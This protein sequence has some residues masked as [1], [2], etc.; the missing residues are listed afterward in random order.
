MIWCFRRHW[1][2]LGVNNKLW[3]AT[4]IIKKS[5]RKSHLYVSSSH[6]K[7]IE[8]IEGSKKVELL[9]IC[10]LLL[11]KFI[12]Y[13]L[14]LTF[15]IPKLY[16]VTSI[17]LVKASSHFKT[18]YSNPNFHET[19]CKLSKDEAKCTINIR[20]VVPHLVRCMFVT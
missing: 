14:D 5:P 12:L 16:K 20:R 9:E 8:V 17:S 7:Y 13:E 2:I 11:V 1:D 15:K 4:Y 18:I 19:G 10:V 6:I 3:E